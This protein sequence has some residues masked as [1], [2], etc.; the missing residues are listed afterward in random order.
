MSFVGEKNRE[1]KLKEIEEDKVWKIQNKIEDTKSEI[2]DDEEEKRRNAIIKILRK[3][4]FVVN[5]KNNI[6]SFCLDHSFE[7]SFYCLVEWEEKN[8]G[9]LLLYDWL[10][11]WID[12]NIDYKKIENVLKILCKYDFFNKIQ[13]EEKLGLDGYTVTLEVKYEQNYKELIMWC[14]TG[15]ILKD[16]GNL[17]VDYAD[18]NIKDL[19]EDIWEY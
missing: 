15:G 3:D 17:L 10:D 8:N 5:N 12:K 9:K 19:S 4:D 18:L 13:Y 11:I 1:E 7:G 6:I 14:P 2:Y 16:I